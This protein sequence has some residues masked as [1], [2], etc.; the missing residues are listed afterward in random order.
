[1]PQILIKGHY[2][3]LHS[4]PDG[5]S[6]H[7]FPDDLDACTNLR[8]KALVSQAGDVAL[9]ENFIRARRPPAWWTTRSI[10]SPTAERLR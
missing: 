8:L 3:I 7:F 9:A 1:M 4:Q 5:D 2:R 10:R 6:V